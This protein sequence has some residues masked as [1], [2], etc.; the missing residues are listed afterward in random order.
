MLTRLHIKDLAIVTTLDTEFSDGM[1]VL[2]GET[3]AG[4]S[5]LIDALGLVLGDRAE[6]S[7]IRAGSERAEVTALFQLDQAEAA[8]RWLRE[9]ELDDGT[10]CMV[11]RV[12]LR[13]GHSRA[14]VNG[15]PVTL[16]SLQSLGELL[17]DI[18]GQHAHLSLL[19]ADRQRELLD[20]YAG[21]KERSDRVAKLFNDWRE[22]LKERD[23]VSRGVAEKSARI[24][25]LRF[26]IDELTG[27]ALLPGEAEEIDREQ[28]RLSSAGE[29]QLQAT[30]LLE[31]LDGETSS[32]RS[33]LVRANVEL[34]AMIRLEPTLS[35][36]REMLE[37]AAIQIDEAI[38]TLRGFADNVELDPQRLARVEQRL[39][40]IQDLARKYRCRPQELTDR[41]AD[42]QQEL[43]EIEHI[44]SQLE[45]LTRRCAELE[46]R[47]MAE[48]DLLHR[49]RSSAAAELGKTVSADIRKLGMPGGKVEVQ[50]DKQGIE[51][52]SA[53]G[54]DRIAFQVSANPGQPLQPLAKTA[55]GGELARI[56]LAIQVATIRCGNV[57]TL[58]FDEV[59]VGIGGSVAEIV[60]RLLYSLG[61]QRQVFCVTHLPQVAARGRQH[62]SVRKSSGDEGTSVEIADL[63]GDARVREVARMLGGID[64]TANTLSHASEMI[65]LMAD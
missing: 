32:A 65:S 40:Q 56:S 20:E 18:Q 50:V 37:S 3:G 63:R 43:D 21:N 31:L 11:R 60:G 36:C 46:Q 16:K 28:R 38:A 30:R 51:K 27:L 55:S 6:I 34:D 41:L 14:F 24:D 62:L 45:Q 53:N 4:K 58:I 13:E 7:M 19:R 48:A 1:T 64:I 10:G 17:V 23:R 22:T 9:H 54:L 29:L 49:A 12:L 61:A 52:A 15:S 2:T 8:S 5:I 25:L 26:Q 39:G 35:D 33:R 44:D 57:P 42:M 47:Y 59:D